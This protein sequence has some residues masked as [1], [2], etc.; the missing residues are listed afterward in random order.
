VTEDY[1]IGKELEIRKA[2]SRTH[3]YSSA[4]FVEKETGGGETKFTLHGA[5]WATEWIVPDRCSRHG[6]L[7]IFLQGNTHALFQNA[8]LNKIY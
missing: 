7:R 6:C 8:S 1:I 3:L 2:L 4:F 5:G